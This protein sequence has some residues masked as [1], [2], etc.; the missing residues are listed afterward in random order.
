MRA[1]RACGGT[2][3]VSAV[4]GC[5]CEPPHALMSQGWRQVCC[6]PG[7]EFRDSLGR[8]P[9]FAASL[10]PQLQEEPHLEKGPQE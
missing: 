8:V 2:W 5:F 4:L 10:G 1:L 3:D 6:L 9:S 7:G